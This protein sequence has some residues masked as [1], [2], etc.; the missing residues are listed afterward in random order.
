MNKLFP[1]VLALLFFSCEKDILDK[2]VIKKNE[3]KEVNNDAEELLGV[4]EAKEGRKWFRAMDIKKDGA[5]YLLFRGR[6]SSGSW[7]ISNNKICIQGGS[8][9]Q[10]DLGEI[11]IDGRYECL[12]YKITS[13][14]VVIF[15]DDWKIL[16]K[17][18]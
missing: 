7:E 8:D 15:Y 18:Q 13:D 9:F 6:V 14:E 3:L 5:I 10:E 4:Y 16:K 12:N 17:I 11:D 2:R 1:I